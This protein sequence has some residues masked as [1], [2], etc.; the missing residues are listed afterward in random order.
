MFGI[1]IEFLLPMVDTIYTAKSAS[2]AM[3]RHRRAKT[4]ETGKANVGT[5]MEGITMDPRAT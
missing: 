1:S 3:A 2:M 4:R 5:K